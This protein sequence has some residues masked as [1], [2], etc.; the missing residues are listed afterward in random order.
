M[1]KVQNETWV[2][3]MT[4][5]QILEL[6][7]EAGFPRD[8][9]FYRSDQFITFAN[10]I[11]QRTLDECAAKIKAEDDYCVTEGDYMLDSDDCIRVING[12][13]VRP[14]YSLGA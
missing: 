4:P 3:A 7:H 9:I 6:A 5:E 11:A 13:W 1:E 2:G 14:D 12:T 10:A 8:T